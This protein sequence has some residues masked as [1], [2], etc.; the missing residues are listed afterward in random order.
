MS[1][2]LC[3]NNT[4][5]A[6]TTTDCTWNQKIVFYHSQRANSPLKLID[7]EGSWTLWSRQH[8]NLTLF[9][10][11]SQS[12]ERKQGWHFMLKTSVRHVTHCIFSLQLDLPQSAANMSEPV[13]VLLC[14]SNTDRMEL[15][16]WT[17]TVLLEEHSLIW[18]LKSPRIFL[19]F[20]NFLLA[21]TL[22]FY[23]K[24]K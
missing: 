21:V 20:K 17:N 14:G 2:S 22:F 24:K 8:L 7:V 11:A 15:Q 10:T 3:K 9:W 13:I 1:D 23:N 16:S 5:R 4:M 19:E 18:W 12:R 6:V